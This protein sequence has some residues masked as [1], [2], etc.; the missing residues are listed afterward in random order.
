MQQNSN[1]G[2]G[3]GSFMNVP[4]DVPFVKTVAESTRFEL[5]RSQCPPK[6]LVGME[7]IIQQAIEIVKQGLL[8]VTSVTHRVAPL[9]ML[10]LSRGGKS[11]FLAYLFDAL[12][13]F[14]LEDQKVN[15]MVISFNGFGNFKPE[16]GETQTNAIIR[17][18]VGQLVDSSVDQTKIRCTAVAL[19]EHIGDFPFVL[20]IDELNRLNDPLDRN[21]AHLLQDLFLRKK[22]RYLVFTSHYRMNIDPLASNGIESES[23]PGVETIVHPVFTDLSIL[24]KMPRCESINAATVALYGGIPSL[25]YSVRALNELNPKVRFENAGLGAQLL[26]D[27]VDMSS[28]L[29]QFVKAVITG[30]RNPNLKKFEQFAIITATSIK[31]PICYI[32]CILGLFVETDATRFILDECIHLESQA[33]KTGGGLDWECIINIALGF[34]CLHAKFFD[35]SGSPFNIVPDGENP[36]VLAITL[37]DDIRSIEVAKKY[38]L[39]FVVSS[40]PMTIPALVLATPAYSSFPIVDGFVAYIS[41]SE[42]IALYG[43]QAKLGKG[44]PNKILRNNTQGLGKGILLQGEAPYID[45]KPFFKGWEHWNKEQVQVLLGSS[46]MDLYPE[47]WPQPPNAAAAEEQGSSKKLKS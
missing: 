25:I 24:R 7:G 43:Y 8:D 6:Y 20:L 46:L 19:D 3:S 1:E 32:K 30:V 16:D 37:P 15:V 31:W 47:N 13:D 29:S 10:R 27:G 36:R 23:D 12:K 26:N 17:N 4:Q 22:N 21:A 18:I 34:R 14:V 28:L 41:S 35:G 2:G 40:I 45:D 5:G 11:T 44:L 38:I 33:S 42:K 39:R 9:A